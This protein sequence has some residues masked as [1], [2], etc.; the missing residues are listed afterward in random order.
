MQCLE[1]GTW[2]RQVTWFK[3][4]FQKWKKILLRLE[5][6]LGNN[7]IHREQINALKWQSNGGW[8]GWKNL[9]RADGQP[10]RWFGVAEEQILE[11]SNNKHD[12][13]F[14]K[15]YNCGWCEFHCSLNICA[16]KENGTKQKLIICAGGWLL[17][18][19]AA[20]RWWSNRTHCWRL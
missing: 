10:S 20:K 12:N 8:K 4:K 16:M 6:P 15:G 1:K 11:K 7:I 13:V 2:L 5:A 9:G 14:I 17:R 18:L 19:E 3:S